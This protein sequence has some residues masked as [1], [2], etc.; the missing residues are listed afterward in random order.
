MWL[1]HN[2][3]AIIV[4]VLVGVAMFLLYRGDDVTAPLADVMTTQQYKSDISYH[5]ENNILAISNTAQTAIWTITIPI[6]YDPT[7]VKLLTGSISSP[8]EYTFEQSR[9]WKITLIVR[10]SL[11]VW[12]IVSIPTVWDSS[13]ISIS[14]PTLISD[15]NTNTSLTIKR[16]E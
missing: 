16:I 10:G 9:N 1:L 7:T 13:N 5:I 2:K 14:S 12:M 4:G 11:D 8:Y 15:T 6:S 3:S